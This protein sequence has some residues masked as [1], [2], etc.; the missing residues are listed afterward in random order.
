[1]GGAA[2]TSARPLC[3]TNRMRAVR[4]LVCLVVGVACFAPSPA[5]A[6]QVACAEVISEVN[7]SIRVNGGVSPELSRVARDV[8]ASPAWVEHCMRVYGRRAR[9]PGL[10][11]TEGRESRL[12]RFES[13]EP[14]ETAPEDVEEAGDDVEPRR[15]EK[16]PVIRPTP[17]PPRDF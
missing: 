16:P 5:R 7:R 4:L 15:R 3:Y 13:D 6:G 11:S 12:E 10:E 14:E 17:E 9:R 8:G 1:V 2:L